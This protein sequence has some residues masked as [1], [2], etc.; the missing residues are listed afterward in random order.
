ME[1][2]LRFF[3]TLFLIFAASGL[4]IHALAL[5]TG[6]NPS[7]PPAWQLATA[8]G[9]FH[10][11]GLGAL[12]PF[13]RYH[14]TTWRGG[15]GL[16]SPPWFRKALYAVGWTVPALATA[17]GTHQLCVMLLERLGYPPNSQAAVDAVRQAACIWERLALLFFA[18]GTAP[19]FEELVFRGVLWPV[20][21][22]RGLRFA[23]AMSVSFLFALIH[24]NVAAFVPLC[25]LGLFW[26]WLYEKTQDLTAPMLSHA[27][28]NLTNFIWILLAPSSPPPGG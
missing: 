21:R 16:F 14:Q 24:A 9:L 7:E 4:G 1:P 13:L 17:W 18:A 6:T 12:V 28:F 15:F 2:T 22:D 25:I 10:L 8:T 26:I 19:V 11:A 5:A 20:F 3:A 23:G 27:L